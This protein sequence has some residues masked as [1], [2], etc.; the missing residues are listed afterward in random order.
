MRK[1][2]LAAM[3]AALVGL[4]ACAQH[5]PNLLVRDLREVPRGPADYTLTLKTYEQDAEGKIRLVGSADA[6]LAGFVSRSMA[7]KGY[8][9]KTAGAARYTL[10]AHLLCANPR[11]ADMGLRSEEVRLP[12]EAVGPS[13]HDELHY[14]L[15]GES[16]P[17]AALD[18]LN[19]RDSQT[20]RRPSGALDRPDATR[21]STA[22]MTPQAEPCQGRVLLLLSP[23]GAKTPREVFVARGSTADCSATAQCPISSCRN[24]LER[25]LVDMIEGRL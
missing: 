21:G 9:L 19:R 20:R 16:D 6:S 2:V 5:D 8:T 23:A 15:P 11:Q 4:G 24:N 7:G 3:M 25:E 1:L 18:S 17:N 22:L 14:W 10:E 13:Y 12:A